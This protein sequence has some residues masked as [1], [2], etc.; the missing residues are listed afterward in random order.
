MWHADYFF[1][2]YFLCLNVCSAGKCEDD[3]KDENCSSD[4]N[5]SDREDA[6]AAGENL[7]VTEDIENLKR[8]AEEGSRVCF[9]FF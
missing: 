3:N 1:Q 5:L 2:F 6:W 4:D 9:C 8:Y 7:E